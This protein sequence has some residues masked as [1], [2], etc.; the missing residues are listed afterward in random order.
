LIASRI[1]LLYIDLLYV[2]ITIFFIFFYSSIIIPELSS[3]SLLV[4]T[5]NRSLLVL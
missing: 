4:F 1:F 3:F 5:I 2:V